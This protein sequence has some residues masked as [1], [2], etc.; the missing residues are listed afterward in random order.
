[1]LL[2][3]YC[4]DLCYYYCCYAIVVCCSK[5]YKHYYAIEPAVKADRKVT[6]LVPND[7]YDLSMKGDYL[8]RGNRD[9]IVVH[10]RLVPNDGY[11]LS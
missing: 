11:D 7:R 3:C 6:R 10:K 2:L 1:M 4:C 8:N 9:F 5:L